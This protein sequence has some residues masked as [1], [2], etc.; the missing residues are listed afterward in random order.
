MTPF[1]R[2][3][4]RNV[5]S[6]LGRR[7]VPWVLRQFAKLQLTEAT[8]PQADPDRVLRRVARLGTLVDHAGQDDSLAAQARNGLAALA[9]PGGWAAV[10]VWRLVYGFAPA[11]W[12]A[13]ERLRGALVVGLRSIA[14]EV[15]PSTAA[16]PFTTEEEALLRAHAGAS[17]PL[18]TFIPR[19][20]LTLVEFVEPPT[21]VIDL[22]AAIAI[23]PTRTSAALREVST[24]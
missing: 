9:G 15:D 13:D 16:Y 18:W 17:D 7:D 5:A 14:H 19:P 23:H 3:R 22:T 21:D 2:L 10:G 20:R 24:R 6:T 1:A 8:D 4:Y 11:D 12:R